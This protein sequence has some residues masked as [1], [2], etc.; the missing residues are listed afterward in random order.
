MSGEVCRRGVTSR[1]SVWLALFAALVSILPV[2]PGTAAAEGL[3]PQQ[4][5][6]F[7]IYK[8]LV[9]INTVTATSSL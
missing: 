2:M 5:L 7:D 4:Q 6:A 3:S 9:E 8:E 1:N